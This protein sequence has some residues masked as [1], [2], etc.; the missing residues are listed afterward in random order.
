MSEDQGIKETREMIV[1]ILEIAILLASRFKDGMQLD[2]ATAIFDAIK[3]DE[4]FKAKIIAGFDN[5][6]LIPAEVKDIGMLE[7]IELASL[8]IR[9]MPS[10][11]FA[12]KK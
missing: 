5:Y 10:I 11:I 3:N 7:S 1:A 12:L 4:E 8:F 6:K 9:Y 2:D